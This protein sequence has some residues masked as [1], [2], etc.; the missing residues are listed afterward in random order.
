M[1]LVNLWSL[2]TTYGNTA[3]IDTLHL[4]ACGLLLLSVVALIG[5]V[6]VW[7]PAVCTTAVVVASMVSSLS[8]ILWSAAILTTSALS[9]SVVRS[10]KRDLVR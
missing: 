9:K 10:F 6:P 7:S 4:L 2:V 5:V 3:I 1:L 8:T